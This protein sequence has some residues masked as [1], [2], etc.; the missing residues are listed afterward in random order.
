MIRHCKAIVVGLVCC[1]LLF[2]SGC[3]IQTSNGELQKNAVYLF[4]MSNASAE[5]LRLPTAFKG[6]LLKTRGIG[7]RETLSIRLRGVTRKVARSA[8]KKITVINERP[9]NRSPANRRPAPS[10]QS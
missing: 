4:E 9:A 7:E 6:R 10:T 1:T 8:F 3:E 5:K 2:L